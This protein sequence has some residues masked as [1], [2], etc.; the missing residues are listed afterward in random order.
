MQTPP[1]FWSLRLRVGNGDG[2]TDSAFILPLR[3]GYITMFLININTLIAQQKIHSYFHTQEQTLSLS[4]S[5]S[6]SLFLVLSLK[7]TEKPQL[8]SFS[9]CRNRN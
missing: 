1:L 3:E 9:E 5:L 4:L 2:E 8:L 6:L 7:L